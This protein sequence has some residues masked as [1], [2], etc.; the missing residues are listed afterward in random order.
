MNPKKFANLKKVVEEVLEK[1]VELVLSEEER[2]TAAAKKEVFR[3]TSEEWL[4][5]IAEQQF[6]D[7]PMDRNRFGHL[8]CQLVLSR[9][10][11]NGQPR[12]QRKKRKYKLREIVFCVTGGERRWLEAGQRDVVGV[13]CRFRRCLEPSHLV[14]EDSAE[15]NDRWACHGPDADECQ[16]QPPCIIN[17]RADEV[18]AADKVPAADQAPVIAQA[19]SAPVIA[20]QATFIVLAVS[21]S[22]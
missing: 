20:H 1:P 6:S 9:D 14:V 13:R 19:T 17:S 11:Q 10:T 15:S 21:S 4:K 5:A 2:K 18:P 3:L 8:I 22:W 7:S 12:V 16:H